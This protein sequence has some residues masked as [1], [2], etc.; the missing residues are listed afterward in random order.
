MKIFFAS[1]SILLFTV[2]IVF[3][4]TEKNEKA[5]VIVKQAVEKLGGEK[6]L[7]VQ[8]QIGRGKFSVLRDGA[9]ISFQTFLDVIAFP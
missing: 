7:T 9:V 6:Y 8:S 2:S 3:A 5:E 4:Q 1:I